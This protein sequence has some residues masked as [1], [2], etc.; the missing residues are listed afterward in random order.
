MLCFCSRN[1]NPDETSFIADM[2]RLQTMR[3]F[4]TVADEGGFAAAA[5]TLDLSAAAVTRLIA[6]LEA[7]VGTRLLHRTTRRVSLTDAGHAY[8]TRVRAILADVEEAFAVAQAHT[9]EMAGVLRLQAPPVL[10]VNILA[11]MMADFQLIHPHVVVEIHVDA[12]GDL[13]VGDHDITL[14]IAEDGYDGNVIARP[15]MSG[16]G[17]LCASPGYLARNGVPQ[18]PDDLARHRCLVRRKSDMRPGTLRLLQTEENDRPIDAPVNAVCITNHSETLLRAAVEGAGISALPL[19]LAAP[20]LE[21]GRLV[22]V[23]APWSCGRFTIYAALPSRK[24]M[25]ARARA[26]LDFMAHHMQG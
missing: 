12:S 19:A 18:T 22:R 3:V 1:N 2:D 5:R 9:V 23:L 13:A 15:I 8:L 16:D 17:V 7:H 20:L 26:F 25:P 10:A 21:D 11:P 14:L 6:D 24:F 4:Q